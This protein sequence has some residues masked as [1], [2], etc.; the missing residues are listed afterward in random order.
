MVFLFTA[1]QF[2]GDLVSSEEGRVFWLEVDE[3]LKTNWIWH[4]DSLLQILVD[5][6]YAELFLDAAD[7]WKAVLK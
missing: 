5:G 3:V 6:K 2:S 4:M 7:D 1:D